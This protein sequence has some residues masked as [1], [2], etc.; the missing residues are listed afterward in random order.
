MQAASYGVYDR[1]VRACR[2]DAST[3]RRCVDAVRVPSCS[4]NGSAV[5]NRAQATQRRA[6]LPSLAEGLVHQGNVGEEAVKIALRRY[7]PMR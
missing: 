7:S 5:S 6:W 2:S 4:A 1:V 3:R